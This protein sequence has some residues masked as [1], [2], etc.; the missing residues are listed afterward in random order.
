MKIN[1]KLLKNNLI[2]QNYNQSITV[3][4]N[5]VKSTDFD[6]SKT[7]YTPMGIVGVQTSDNYICMSGYSLSNNTAT[8]RYVNYGS[9]AITLTCNLT[10]LYRKD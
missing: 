10:V 6:V 5:G 7:G 2:A 1:P 4:G 8:V 9:R 3:S